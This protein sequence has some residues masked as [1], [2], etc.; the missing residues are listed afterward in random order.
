MPSGE[1]LP[2]RGG[3]RAGGRGVADSDP[4]VVGRRPGNVSPRRTAHPAPRNAS[5]TP[6]PGHA[7]QDEGGAWPADDLDAGVAG[8]R[9]ARRGARRAAR[10]RGPPPPVRRGRSTRPA[11]P[12]RA[13][14]PTSAA[15][16][17]PWPRSVPPGRARSPRAG[18]PA[19]RSWS[20]CG[21]RPA[22]AGRTSRPGSPAR[23]APCR[24]RPRRRAAPARAARAGRGR[25][26]VQHR[27]RVGGVPQ[28]DE[29]GVL[30]HG[31]GIQ[32][33]AGPG[34][35]EEPV[36]R[37]PGSAQRG[38]GFGEGGVHDDRAP[39]RTARASRV[40]ASAAPAVGSTSSTLRPWL[41]ATAC[42]AGRASG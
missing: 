33:V 17:P 34:V 8:Q 1:D 6:S 30:R 19:P 22:R 40:N 41:R 37:V 5:R 21:R 39:G 28:H 36:D 9:A 31:G 3:E 11:P 4:Q 32:A 2:E 20:G 18:R 15:A 16:A 12:A 23:P 24:R 42:R 13:S 35:E 7:E 29:V 27:G 10:P 14:T 25:G 38:L 26:R